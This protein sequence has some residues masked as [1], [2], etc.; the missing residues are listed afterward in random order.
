VFLIALC[1]LCVAGVVLWAAFKAPATEEPYARRA[2]GTLRLPG[3]NPASLDPAH[4]HDVTSSEYVSEIYSGLVSLGPDLTVRPD[5]AE[6]WRIS[7]DGL[8][9]TFTMT[10]GA[11]FHDGR[12]VSASDVAF[13]IERACDPA[14][15]SGVAATYLGDIVG[16]VA[17][18]AGR[19]RTVSGVEIV[20]ASEIVL[21]LDAPKSYFLSKLT[22]PV[23]Y[24]VDSASIDAVTSRIEGDA[25]VNAP[26]HN[27]TGPF[28][29]ARYVP[30]EELVLVRNAE[31][32]GPV[33]TLEE[34]VF[35]LRPVMAMTMYEN[36]ELDATPLGLA[37]RPRATDPLNSLS[38]E[39]LEGEG[40][41]ATSYLAMNTRRPPF[42]EPE[43]RRAVYQAIDRERLS[44]IVLD[45]AVKTA[46]GIVPPGMP[47]YRS[48][49]EPLHYD[50]A[51]AARRPVDWALVTAS[52][53]YL[54]IPGDGAAA[55][56]ADAIAEDLR[57]NLGLDVRV[58]M[59]SW[60]L[61]QREVRDGAYQM[62]MLGWV[63]D[64]PDPQNFLDLLFHSEADLN[65]T[66]YAND[67]VD[68]LL[69][70]ARQELDPQARMDLYSEAERT[71]LIDA[72]WVP[73]H[74]ATEVW[75]VKPYV[76]N[77]S[78]PPIVRPRLA[79]IRLD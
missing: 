5:L 21:R 55:P 53:I 79:E 9:Y 70:R 30:D 26:L 50:P 39:V 65:V 37:D 77:F 58:E 27:G 60:D 32:Y 43:L 61:F 18:L 57:V 4:V 24:V 64:Y 44:R 71:I 47:G 14:T 22:Y 76:H 7:P 78:V 16:C 40:E 54:T 45:G 2:G 25:T 33:A 28:R 73:L 46:A 48:G 23:A 69:E 51:A 66:G 1:G 42:D 36:G 29:L 34:V 41:L 38:L 20:S 12:A 6:S 59:A 63:A 56:T 75:L 13:S 10:A 31:F 67:V 11:L 68:S 49:N 19:A 3:S 8:V 62:W 35:D 17:K 52:P 72:P 74:H 15:G